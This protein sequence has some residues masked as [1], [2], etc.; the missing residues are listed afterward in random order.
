MVVD[1]GG[2]GCACR[3]FGWD[4]GYFFRSFWLGL[5]FVKTLR[6]GLHFFVVDGT[7]FCHGRIIYTY[8]Y[9]GWTVTHIKY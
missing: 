4:L 1:D 9:R 6:C 2:D 8:V 5:G 3:V 7:P